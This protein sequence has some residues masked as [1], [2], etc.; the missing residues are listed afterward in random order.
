MTMRI[1]TSDRL[2]GLPI[3]RAR[4]LVRRLRDDTVDVAT[5]MAELSLERIP[6]TRLLNAML[7]ESYIEPHPTRSEVWLLTEKASKLAH[8][9]AAPPMTRDVAE[10]TLVEVIE[11][12][13]VM[14][15][16]ECQLAFGVWQLFVFG[17][18]LTAAEL[19]NDLDVAVEWRPRFQDRDKQFAHERERTRQARRAGRHFSNLSEEMFF[20]HYEA[21]LFLKGKSSRISLHDAIEER[22]FLET[23][24]KRLVY[25]RVDKVL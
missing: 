15:A 18:Y 3:T 10:R 17:S 22:E 20:P 7:A 23:V 12:A 1:R 13:K 2:G 4:K 19:L 25:R 14:N 9:A 16:P 24:P 21:R 11:R 6:A 8:A 5:I